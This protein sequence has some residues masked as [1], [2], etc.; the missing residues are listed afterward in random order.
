VSFQS[1][2]LVALGGAAGTLLRWLAG[3]ALARE[4]W[5]DFPWGTLAVNVIGSFAL[6]VVAESMADRRLWGVDARLVLGT[7][8]M[9]GF[10]T[11]STFNLETLRYF[12]R[13]EHGRAALYVAVT[14]GVC[15]LAGLGGLAAGRALR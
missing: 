11:Y 15:L 12:E 5:P 4:G 9:G 1:A 8:V 13:G 14:L 7:G 10:T 6:G 3:L 2:L